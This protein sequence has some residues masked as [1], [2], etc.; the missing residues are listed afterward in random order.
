M[1][2]HGVPDSRFA[3][4]AR[5]SHVLCV[6]ERLAAEEDDLPFQKGVTDLFQLLQ[7]QGLGEIHAPDLS[8]N[9]QSERHHFD[10]RIPIGPDA[11]LRRRQH[12]L[13]PSYD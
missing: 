2:E 1:A 4:L 11:L 5:H 8:T 10:G 12:L 7:R 6:I 9:M 3:K 13:S